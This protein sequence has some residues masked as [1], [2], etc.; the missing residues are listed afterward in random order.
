MKKRYLLLGIALLTISSC[1]SFSMSDFLNTSS[2]QISI[3]KTDIFDGY[4]KASDLRY[5]FRDL[6]SQIG[7]NTSISVGNQ[8]LLVVPVE[9]SDYKNDYT[10]EKLNEL[11]TAFF[12]KAEDTTFESVSSFFYESSYGKLSLSG[13]VTD[14]F[15]SKYSSNDLMTLSEKSNV[16]DY[17]AEEFV[18]GVDTSKYDD[19]DLDKDGFI[20]NCIF[21]YSND[22]GRNDSIDEYFNSFWAWCTY[23][24]GEPNISKPSVN[25]YMWASYYF[26]NDNYKDNY[27]SSKIDSHT[28]I[29]ETGHLLGLDDYYCY[30]ESSNNIKPWDCAGRLDMQSYNVGDH[31]AFSKMA[32]GWIDPY[33]VDGTQDVTN[34][35]LKTSSKYPEA[36]IINDNWNGSSFDEYI[37]VEYYTPTGLNEIDSKHEYTSS[38]KMYDYNGLRIYHVDARIIK[39]TIRNGNLLL[40]KNY[41][42]EIKDDNYYY[43]VGASNSVCYSYLSENS[44][45]YRLLHLLD[46][47]RKNVMNNGNGNGG[48]YSNGGPETST[49]LWTGSKTFNPSSDFFANGTKFNDRSTIG[50]SIS[51]SNLT[52]EDCVVTISKLEK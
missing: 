30:D 41:T 6:N 10:T 28:Y 47:G 36:I 46:Q 27:N 49:A 1:D 16:S 38:N 31:N 23:Y 44:K 11:N 5:T 37:L 32:L 2:L 7:W 48:M 34:I 14:V 3:D 25:N 42:D 24:L 50:Y 20:D 19:Y 40:S 52:N 4:Y 21:I 51:V 12:G 9:L 15:K 17:I 18:S 45:K 33:V 22:Y 39:T 8:K 35:Q 43:F 13:K 26:I 29:H